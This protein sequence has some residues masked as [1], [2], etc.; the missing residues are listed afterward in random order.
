MGWIINYL[1]GSYIFNLLLI[2]MLFI[3][4]KKRGTLTGNYKKD[5]THI[6]VFTFS[7]FTSPI[8]LPFIAIYLMYDYL[9]NTML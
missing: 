8:V 7:F 5:K 9:K 6:M 3:S 1:I 2:S 4:M